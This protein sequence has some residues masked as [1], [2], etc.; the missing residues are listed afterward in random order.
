[1]MKKQRNK[2]NNFILSCL[3]GA[4]HMYQGFFKEGTSLMS[5]FFFIIL[6]AGWLRFEP[7]IFILPVLWFY[8]FFDS[9]NRNSVPEEEFNKFEDHFLWIDSI[10]ADKFLKPKGFR[11]GLAI[12]LIL[13]GMD[14]L[15][16]NIFDILSQCF[17]W[18]FV[19]R[20]EYVFSYVP[21]IIVAIL[22]IAVGVH[23]IIGKKKELDKKEEL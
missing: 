10:D 15:I 19:Y 14:V 4:G 3:P 17:G 18:N 13:I 2:F 1:M 11:T 22:I 12:V 23:L 6:I 7:I 9:L 16:Q 5:L 21:Q 20:L 8:S